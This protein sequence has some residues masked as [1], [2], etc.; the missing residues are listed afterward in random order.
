MKKTFFA[1]SIIFFSLCVAAQDTKKIGLSSWN[2]GVA[3]DYVKVTNGNGEVIYEDDFNADN[4]QWELC[5][6]WA[7]KNGSLMCD[8]NKL[9]GAFCVCKIPT[10]DNYTF[11]VKARKLSGREGFLVAYDLLNY[12]NYSLINLGG[13]DNSQHGVQ[14]SNFGV[15]SMGVSSRGNIETNKEYDIRI[16]V[17]NGRA[18]CYLNGSCIMSNVSN[19]STSKYTGEKIVMKLPEEKNRAKADSFFAEGKKAQQQGDD[20][21]A[22]ENFMKAAK[23]GHAIACHE[24]GMAF[25]KGRGTKKDYYEMFEWYKKSAE[26]GYSKAMNYLA[27]AYVNGNGTRPDKTAAGYW[28]QKSIE[29]DKTY[30]WPYVNLSRRFRNG[31]GVTQTMGESARLLVLAAEYGDNEVWKS[32]ISSSREDKFFPYN[33]PDAI[34]AVDL[35]NYNLGTMG[36]PFEASIKA[37]HPKSVP[38]LKK[39]A[40]NGD[41]HAQQ[42]IA[43]YLRPGEM[44]GIAEN[45]IPG[46]EFPK[47][48]NQRSAQQYEG[49]NVKRFSSEKEFDDYLVIDGIYFSDKERRVSRYRIERSADIIELERILRNPEKRRNKDIIE[50]AKVICAYKL[51][52]PEI[53]QTQMHWDM[54][55]NIYKVLHAC[56]E[57]ANAKGVPA[58][59]DGSKIVDIKDAFLEF[60]RRSISDDLYLFHYVYNDWGPLSEDE[61]FFTEHNYILTRTPQE[62]NDK[63]RIFFPNGRYVGKDFNEDAW[64]EAYINNYK[65]VLKKNDPKLWID[66]ESYSDNGISY[67]DWLHYPRLSKG[68]GAYS[69]NTQLSTLMGSLKNLDYL[70]FNKEKLSL[71]QSLFS[72]TEYVFKHDYYG[73]DY[74]NFRLDVFNALS[75]D[76]A[77]TYRSLLDAIGAA[78]QIDDNFCNRIGTTGIYSFQQWYACHEIMYYLNDGISAARK[79]AASTPEIRPACKKAEEFI[80]NKI[81]MLNNKVFIHDEAWSRAIAKNNRAGEA[82]AKL[83]QE[84]ENL[85]LPAYQYEDVKWQNANDFELSRKICF[86]D[87]SGVSCTTI[88]KAKNGSYFKTPAGVFYTSKY[89]TERDAIIAAYA[90]LKYGE[91]R[92]KGRIK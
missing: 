73:S 72:K 87:L 50:R 15:R 51:V 59:W 14:F 53:N 8:N 4:G 23:L 1:I 3:Y 11:M 64:I 13:W 25:E 61:I 80:R 60:L 56:P 91:V 68:I 16:D 31:D 86:N 77:R 9:E 85:G 27:V 65:R 28:Y 48:D 39:M 21:T 32:I 79:L 78:A 46:N 22:F 45:A 20:K 55:W 26:L 34:F 41:T 24:V 92:Q 30:A 38:Y 81:A 83:L 62:L 44:P 67:I 42:L 70:G 17:N 63:Y 33:Y 76:E 52:N 90:Y 89:R 10:G 88:F 2:T 18:T 19:Q 6:G 74:D 71:F 35:A 54:Y 43:E 5:G 29:T 47:V 69:E 84:I 37:K 75:N 58:T 66:R 57:V 36:N 40:D 7:I 12:W 82:D 49:E